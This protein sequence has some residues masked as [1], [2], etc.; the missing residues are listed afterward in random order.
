MCIINNDNDN[1]CNW[2]IS[3]LLLGCNFVAQSIYYDSLMLDMFALYFKVFAID[4]VSHLSMH[5]AL[6]KSLA[7]ARLAINVMNT[8]LTGM[9]L[10]DNITMF[11]ERLILLALCV[12]TDS[13]HTGV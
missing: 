1:N 12:L 7:V 4:V 9:N 3:I 2:H 13:N 8:M 5:Y 10:S 11:S 6:P